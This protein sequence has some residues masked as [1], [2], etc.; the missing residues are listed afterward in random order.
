[1]TT[2]NTIT[3]LRNNSNRIP[4]YKTAASECAQEYGQE[5]VWV[6][7]PDT[8]QCK[9]LGL[10]YIA[11]DEIVENSAEKGKGKSRLSLRDA[12]IGLWEILFPD[13]GRET[14]RRL[15][16]DDMTPITAYKTGN[17]YYV[18]DGSHALAT[19]RYLG[20]S[21]VLAGVWELP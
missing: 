8:A 15:E 13:R 14:Y 2:T 18:A 4:Y 12:L 5:C 11:L 1:M 10:L 7:L 19:A 16:G 21:F 6:P 9:F 3:G 20:R 17:R